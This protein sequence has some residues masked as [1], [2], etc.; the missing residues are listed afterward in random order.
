MRV[1]QIV[2]ADRSEAAVANELPKQLAQ[3]IRMQR[4]AIGTDRHEVIR[5]SP[6][7]TE[8]GEGGQ[9]DRIDADGPGSAVLRRL[10]DDRATDGGASQSDENGGG[11]EID[12]APPQ[13]GQLTAAH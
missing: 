10:G 1:A 13:A 5:L 12:V 8:I 11:I 6:G 9:G 2:E 3:T 7:P 4:L